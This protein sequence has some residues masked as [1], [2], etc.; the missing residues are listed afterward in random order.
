M[1]RV[2]G[3]LVGLA[4]LLLSTECLLPPSKED[5]SQIS[6]LGVKY[7][8]KQ[9]ENAISGVKEMK[10]VMERSGEDHN[11]FLSALEKTKQQKEDALKAAQ[12]METKLS[13]EQEVCNGTM[14]SLWEECKPCLKNTCIKYYSKTCSS[15][16]RLIGRQLEEVLNRTSP[17]SIWING[18]NMDVLEREDQEQSQR[19][20]NLEERYSDV[21]DGVDSIFM[22]SMR[23][24]DHMRSLNPP[25]FSSPF[26][27]PSIWGQSERAEAGEVRSRMV[28][29]PL[30]DP[31]FHGFHNMF[32]PMMDMARNIFGSMGPV[33]DADANFDINP[34][35]EGSVNED[36]VVTK[37]SGM[38]CRE[39]R[40]NSAG[41]IKLRGEC[42][43]CVAIQ[44]ID[45]SG[46]KPLAGPLK[47][48]LEQ[49]LAMAEKY[50]QEYS[51]RLRRFEEQMSNT[52]SL[53]DLFSKQFGWVSALANNTNDGIF[54]I[55]T[56]MSKDTEDPEKPGETN[57]SVQLFD[58]P[59][60][61]FSVPGDIPWN[62]SKFS[63]VVAQEALDRYKQTTVVVK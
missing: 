19:F 11:K 53:L 38:T 8:D 26:R 44:D 34:S 16:A 51:K 24:F 5:L 22:D 6:L 14:Q 20:Q 50:T 56:V 45:C 43:K 62:D 4:L 27:M 48:D 9:I 46:K 35:E 15:G 37:P 21:A 57:V 7:L 49:A 12:E 39:I 18:E 31:D 61:T 60:M 41:C 58:T 13:E 30:Q 63:E 29:S 42:E 59:A 40:R 32:A 33:M 55:K 10:T 1:M 25:M 36:V 23:V 47:K 17:F 28:R 3:S 2:F 54:K 52:S